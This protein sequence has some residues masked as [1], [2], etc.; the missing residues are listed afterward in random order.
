MLD[1][2]TLLDIRR[3]LTDFLTA[4]HSDESF[5]EILEVTSKVNLAIIESKNNQKTSDIPK[6]ESRPKE[7]FKIANAIA[8]IDKCLF[9]ENYNLFAMYGNNED[10][11]FVYRTDS[12]RKLLSFIESKRDICE[13]N[14]K[15][16][17]VQ[18][19]DGEHTEFFGY[20]ISELICNLKN[21]IN[22]HTK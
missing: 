22:T 13:K 19:R 18:G 16:F 9:T 17:V 6:E 15:N 7:D 21:Y 2:Q 12:L 5:A 20:T 4:Y 10:M 8:K 1:L 3:I 11:D 14:Y